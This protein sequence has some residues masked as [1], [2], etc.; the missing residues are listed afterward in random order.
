[1]TDTEQIFQAIRTLPVHDRLRLV[2]RVVHD[3]ADTLTAELTPPAAS[4]LVGLFAD[5]PELID[6][7]CRWRWM[8]AAKIR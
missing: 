3:L 2:E 1:V 7:V 5:D 4:S 6:D 8:R